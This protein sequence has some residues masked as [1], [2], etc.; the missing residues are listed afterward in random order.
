MGLLSRG[1]LSWGILTR[2][3]VPYQPSFNYNPQVQARRQVNIFSCPG[4]TQS[5]NSFYLFRKVGVISNQLLQVLLNFIPTWP[6]GKPRVWLSHKADEITP[7][8]NDQLGNPIPFYTEQ[9]KLTS[10][11]LNL[12]FK[13]IVAV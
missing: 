13:V 9:V 7:L 10:S 6:K 8:K 3:P 2:D 12:K 4:L 1:I 5:S 11:V